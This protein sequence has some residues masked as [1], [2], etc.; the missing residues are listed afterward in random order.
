MAWDHFMLLYENFFCG[1]NLIRYTHTKIKYEGNKCAGN[2]GARNNHLK[3]KRAGQKRVQ[4][5]S[6]GNGQVRSNRGRDKEMQGTKRSRNKCIGL[7]KCKVQTCRK[8]AMG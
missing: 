1:N 5:K 3:S 4:N 7:K 2:N 8:L 6:T